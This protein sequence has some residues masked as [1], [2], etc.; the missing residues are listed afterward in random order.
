M[1]K[2]AYWDELGIAW[3]TF[4]PNLSDLSPAF[5]NRARRE[6]WLFWAG[7]LI[8]AGL[9]TTGLLLGAW[10]IWLGLTLGAW[11][12]VIRGLAIVM[13]ALLA[14]IAARAF[15]L[16]KGAHND[17]RPVA[18][19]LDLAIIRRRQL[20]LAIRLALCACAVAALFGLAGSA[21]R[22][23][24]SRPPNMSPVVDIIL[25]ALAALSLGLFSHRVKV[26]RAKLQYL[27]RV[28]GVA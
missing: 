1:T 23:H 7:L 25:L 14:A 18:E 21:V 16:V 3:V 17:A 8:A 2:D 5:K 19:M 4:D 26:E 28:L 24:L 15:W 13:I 6:I 12:F 27:R 9:S 22:S 11:N 10:T 20:L